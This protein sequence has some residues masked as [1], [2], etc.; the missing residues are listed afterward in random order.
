MKKILSLILALCTLLSLVSCASGSLET[1]EPLTGADTVPATEEKATE[2]EKAEL[3]PKIVKPL[4]WADINAIPIANA[5]MSEDELRQICVDFMAL[6]LSFPWQSNKALSFEWTDS[7]STT[8]DNITSIELN[9]AYGGMPYRSSAWSNIYQIMYYYDEETGVLDAEAMG[10]K[11]TTIISNM[12]TSSTFW[13]WGRVSN[14]NNWDGISLLMESRGAIRLGNY[15]VEETTDYY[16]TKTSTVQECAKNGEQTM[17]A[18]YALLKKAD[19]INEYDKTGGH[20]EM[21]TQN[22]VVKRNADGTING[23]ESYCYFQDQQHLRKD[24][25]QP[26][27]S[28]LSVMKGVEHKYSFK[29]LYQKGYLP[30]TLAEF[31]GLDPVEK[32]EV[33]FTLG[34]KESLSVK[35]FLTGEIRANYAISDVNITFFDKEGKVTGTHPY[36]MATHKG[37]RNLSLKSAVFGPQAMMTRYI[38]GEGTTMRVD[39]RISTGEVFTVYQGGITK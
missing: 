25:V 10:D 7:L 18:C 14:T 30:F 38:T 11:C 39:V 1:E 6:Q 8:Q 20:V 36:L 13:G 5:S 21:A 26:D 35:D 19:G 12:C 34:D 9:T 22:A 27:G 28:P 24:A 33:S 32:G 37:I 16:I 23:E 15:K 17:Y 3:I 4:T 2:E 29:E 31:H